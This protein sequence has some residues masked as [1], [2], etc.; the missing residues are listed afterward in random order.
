LT[1]AV[2]DDLLAIIV[3]AAFYTDSLSVG[4]LALALVCIVA[5]GALARSPYVHP[6]L[7]APL[8]LVAW[9]LMHASGVHATIA[10]VLLGLAVPARA[11]HGEREDRA[12]RYERAVRPWSTA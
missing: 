6:W 8:G 11:L 3:I 4:A 2:V 7:L 12:H 10:G 1:L 9:A 5:F